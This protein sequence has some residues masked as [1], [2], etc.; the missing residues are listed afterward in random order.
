MAALSE[1]QVPEDTIEY[2]LFPK[3]D[4]R[5]GSF[6]QLDSLRTVYFAFMA[7]LSKDY[8]WHQESIN[9]SVVEERVE[10]GNGLIVICNI[11]I[12]LIHHNYL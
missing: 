4:A 3:L 10:R 8:I 5:D 6:E 9:L 7:N 12:I 11:M 2:F 1:F